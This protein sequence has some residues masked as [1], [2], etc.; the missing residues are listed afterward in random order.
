MIPIA[1]SVKAKRFPIFNIGI[2]ILTV[3]VFYLQ[4]TSP[5]SFTYQYALI[6]SQIDFANFSTLYPFV[7]SIFLHGGFLHIISNMI[8]LWVFGDNVEGHFPFLTYPFLYIGSGIVASLAQYIIS[9]ASNIPM[10]GASGA[11]A[12]ALGAYFVLFPHHKIK[13]FVPFFGFFTM[14]NISAVFMLGYWFVLQILSGAASLS[15]PSDIGGVAF[16]AH[17]GGFVF[18]AAAAKL[19]DLFKHEEQHTDHAELSP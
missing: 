14:V 12:G 10:L 1:D 11:V 15:G 13:T 9:P 8:F 18:G 17:V 5:E 16:W 3:F 2:I 4:I 7:T 6:P 19:L